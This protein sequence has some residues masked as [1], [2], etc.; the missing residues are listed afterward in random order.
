MP[1]YQFNHF[2][3]R[4]R[5]STHFQPLYP[6]SAT[7]LHSADPPKM[8]YDTIKTK[9]ATAGSARSWSSTVQEGKLPEKMLKTMVAY[10]KDVEAPIFLIKGTPD[11]IMFGMSC[12]GLAITMGMAFEFLL[13]RAF[14]PK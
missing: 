5:E 14:P 13:R 6:I 8:I 7:P 4:L 11:K 2:T 10:Q 1:S 9:P 12:V 3:G